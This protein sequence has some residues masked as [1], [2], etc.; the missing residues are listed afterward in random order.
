MGTMKQPYDPI[1]EHLWR[2]V[3]GDLAPSRFEKWVYRERKLESHLGGDLYLK[4]IS[5]DFSDKEATWLLRTALAQH[6]RTRSGS[7]CLCI[8]L[9]DL[10]VVDMGAYWA[11]R[12]A[13][14]SDREWSHEDVFQSLDRVKA[15]G[16]SHWWLWAARCHVCGQGWLVGQ[17]ERQND[18]F[19]MRRLD[20][21]EL[22]AIERYDRW[23]ADF[24]T[25]ER[26]LQIGL[27]WGRSVRFVDPMDSCLG[28][29]V[30]SLAKERPRIAVSD[31]AALLNLDLELAAELARRA[32][33]QE[34]VK[35]TFDST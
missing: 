5:T 11:P 31:L 21:E 2:F 22:E 1:L 10:D 13:F 8:R 29:T 7:D 24:D 17:E 23:P 12:P 6:V 33:E 35:I 32:V 4:T 25:Y 18:L 19:C 14:E 9:K 27:Q 30:A 34:K 16:D 3:R 20:D 28:S 26:L 15:R